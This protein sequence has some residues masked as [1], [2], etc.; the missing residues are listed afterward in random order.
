MDA[1]KICK[2]RPLTLKEACIVQLIRNKIP[3]KHVPRRLRSLYKCIEKLYI[4]KHEYYDNSLTATL[5][6]L[7]NILIARYPTLEEKIWF[8][9]LYT[10]RKVQIENQKSKIV[11]ATLL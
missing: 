9:K 11:L 10:I 1:F 7:L 2:K 8:N 6:I 5:D 4:F 3:K